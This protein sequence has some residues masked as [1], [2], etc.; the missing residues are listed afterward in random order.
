MRRFAALF[1][2]WKRH[3]Y[4]KATLSLL[5]DTVRQK[6]NNDKYFSMKQQMLAATTEKKWKF[7][8]LVCEIPLN[9]TILHSRL[10]WMPNFLV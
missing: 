10:G 1:I 5:S 3:H 8:I 7:G 6:L 4:D 2:C 9:G